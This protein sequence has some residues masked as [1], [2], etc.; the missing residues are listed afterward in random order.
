M[1]QY[2]KPNSGE[3]QC[4]T[5]G[6]NLLYYSPFRTLSIDWLSV[7]CRRNFTEKRLYSIEQAKYSNNVWD[8]I[9]FY[10]INK[11]RIFVLFS[12]PKNPLIPVDTCILKFEN[13]VLYSNDFVSNCVN[14]ITGASLDIIKINR[15]DLALDFQ[16]F[17]N[18]M[19]PQTLIDDI[20]K[21]K[22]SRNGRA[23]FASN[24]VSNTFLRIDYVRFGT[25]SSPVSVYMYNKS[26]EFRDVFVKSY[27]G[28]IWEQA[29]YDKTKD[30][31]RIE[32]S[33]NHEQKLV[34]DVKSGEIIQTVLDNYLDEYYLKVIFWTLFVKYFSFKRVNNKVRKQYWEK[35]TLFKGYEEFVQLVSNVDNVEEPNRM[36]RIVLKKMTLFYKNNK[37]NTEPDLIEFE[38]SI[39]IF[40]ERHN[41]TSFLYETLQFKTIVFQ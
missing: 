29:G 32:L 5:T 7:S 23:K 20:L 8:T 37:F 12:K 21:N 1:T 31:Y 4:S 6:S 38:N 30:V 39:M 34:T 15:I 24:G 2:S 17:A 27:I 22:A 36:N 18:N 14:W 3:T 16:S 11:R 28:D 25:R 40:A 9:E 19:K 13:A 35:I 26:Q 33:I 41:L 10:S